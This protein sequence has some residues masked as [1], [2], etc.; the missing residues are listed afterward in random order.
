MGCIIDPDRIARANNYK[1]ITAGRQALR[2]ID[3]AI[4]NGQSFTQETTLSGHR[5]IK[6]LKKQEQ[7][8]IK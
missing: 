8:D 5:I 4:D 6:T 1:D 2:E 3:Q 7:G